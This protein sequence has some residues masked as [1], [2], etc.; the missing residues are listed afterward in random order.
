MGND[1]HNNHAE[2]RTPKGDGARSARGRE[3]GRPSDPAH[4]E[5]QPAE[6]ESARL[7]AK[8]GHSASSYEPPAR[9]RV[10]RGPCGSAH[11]QVAAE[12]PGCVRADREC[13]F[14][15]ALAEHH[16]L[17]RSAMSMS[18]SVMLAHSD[19]RTPV[20]YIS[21]ISAASR[22]SS[23][24]RPSQAFSSARVLS[25]LTVCKRRKAYSCR[26]WTQ[27]DSNP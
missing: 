17:A 16:D 4:P 23:N 24:V 8:E 12:R 5:P 27:G 20:S 26:W 3:A 21:A 13:A 18:A 14:L 19:R 22:R 25:E 11:P 7:L 10:A 2:R 1:R 9:A 6:V 15:P